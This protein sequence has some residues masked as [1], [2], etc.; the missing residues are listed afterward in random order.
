MWTFCPG[1]VKSCR[2]RAMW[3]AD[4]SLSYLWCVG[5]LLLGP[6]PEPFFSVPTRNG[7]TGADRNDGRDRRARATHDQSPHQGCARRGQSPGRQ[8]RRLSARR[9]QHQAA[10]AGAGRGVAPGVRRA[11][12]LVRLG[13]WPRRSTSATSSPITSWTAAQVDARARTPRPPID[14]ASGTKADGPC[15]KN[16]GP[17][18]YYKSMGC[19]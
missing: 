16:F 4:G 8:A 1:L 5:S 17:Q 7:P 9:I 12:R 13:P 14:R 10:S 19:P 11:C 18:F 2:I 15:A 6:L 3:L